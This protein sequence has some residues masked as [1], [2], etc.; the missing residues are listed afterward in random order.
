[1][2]GRPLHQLALASGHN[3]F[4]HGP[5][6]AEAMASALEL[7][8]SEAAPLSRVPLILGARGCFFW[9]ALHGATLEVPSPLCAVF[10]ASSKLPNG[11]QIEV[12]QSAIKRH[13]NR[14]SW[15]AT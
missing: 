5:A 15:L 3:L 2:P 12:E 14:A 13:T 4:L 11:R 7:R 6:G 10:V 8:G 1:M 9:P